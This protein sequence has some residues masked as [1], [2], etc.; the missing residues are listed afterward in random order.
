MIG[1]IIDRWLK[2]LLVSLSRSQP[3]AGLA[4]W[5]DRFVTFGT[6][7]Y[8]PDIQLRL[9]ILNFI[10]YLIAVTTSIYAVQQSFLD[11]ETY[12]PVILINAVLIVVALS[13]PLLHRFNEIAGGVTLLVAECAALIAFTAYLGSSAGIH[14]QY[15]AMAAAPFVVLG[16]ERIWLIVTAIAAALTLHL[17]AWFNFP[18]EQALIAADKQVLDS[19][20]IQAAVTTMGILGATVWYAF[21]LVERARAETDALLHNILPDSIVARL[22]ARPG[23]V[24]ADQLDNAAVLFADVSGFVALARSLGP[25]GVVSLLN[26]LVSTLDGLAERHG[27]EKI[28]TIG[29]AYMAASG[30]PVA[31]DDYCCRLARMAIDIQKTVFDLRQETGLDLRVR[32]GMASGPMMAGVIGTQKFSYD[33]WGDTVNLAARLEGAGE[34]DRIHVCQASYQLLRDEFELVSVGEVDIKGV[35]AVRTWYLIGAKDDGSYSTTAGKPNSW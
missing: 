12:R 28:K 34:V 1:S 16:L 29:D 15:F 30:V 31:V 33:V 3:V 11:Y 8:A 26:K 23:N 21:R 20:Y 13:I 25:V 9:K 19:L 5:F 6:D 10:C 4:Y 14:I 17:I 22:K 24:I 35:G 27:V 32:V 7:G 2:P 18:P